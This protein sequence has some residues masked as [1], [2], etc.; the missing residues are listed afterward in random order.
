MALP[1]RFTKTDN[2]SSYTAAVVL[3][4]LLAYVLVSWTDS[5]V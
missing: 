1:T 4:V 5:W 3:A 2:R